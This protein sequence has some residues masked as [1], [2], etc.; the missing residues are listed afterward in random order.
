MVL[1]NAIKQ[2]GHLG[3]RANNIPDTKLICFFGVAFC[4]Y[5][6]GLQS[7]FIFELLI[8]FGI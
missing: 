1:E 7:L 6:H 2:N 8:I 3:T 5:L 4:L